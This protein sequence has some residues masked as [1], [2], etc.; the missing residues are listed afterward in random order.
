MQV[1][2]YLLF[3][4]FLSYVQFVA[5]STLL[6]PALSDHFGFSIVHISYFNLGVMIVGF[7]ASLVL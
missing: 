6:A 5:V 1:Y 2:T 3:T 7:G 4:G